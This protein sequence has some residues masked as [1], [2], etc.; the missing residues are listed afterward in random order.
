MTSE[1]QLE[2]VDLTEDEVP[3]RDHPEASSNSSQRSKIYH[4]Y[5]SDALK[6]KFKCNYC[7][8]SMKRDATGST[9]NIIRHMKRCHRHIILPG[10]SNHGNQQTIHKC[11][12]AEQ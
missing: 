12:E 3:C 5:T 8:V 7:T 1:K 6:Q 9:S 4:H 10:S 11:F 2:A